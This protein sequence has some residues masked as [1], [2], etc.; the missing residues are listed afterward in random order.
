MDIITY[1]LMCYG[2]TAAISLLVIAIVLGV[3]KI[4]SKADARNGDN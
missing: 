1:T 3:N 4:M 2:I